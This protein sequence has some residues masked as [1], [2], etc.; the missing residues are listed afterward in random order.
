MLGIKSESAVQPELLFT[1]CFKLDHTCSQGWNILKQLLSQ[2]KLIQLWCKE[3]TAEFLRRILVSSLEP[4]SGQSKWRRVGK[5]SI[6][7][8]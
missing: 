1:V 7:L 6:V 8:N 2:I 3:K 4:I 5:D